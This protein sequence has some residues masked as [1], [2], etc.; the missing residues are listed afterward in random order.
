M[1]LRIFLLTL[2]PNHVQCTMYKVQFAR[3]DII[4]DGFQL[5]KVMK[6]FQNTAFSHI[7]LM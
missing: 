4:M 7:K 6:Y 3:E 1:D 5:A 2:H